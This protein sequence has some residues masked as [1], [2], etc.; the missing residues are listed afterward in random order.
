MKD[1]IEMKAAGAAGVRV[2]KISMSTGGAVVP[3][4]SIVEYWRHMYS[5]VHGRRG[6]DRVE[7]PVYL[8]DLEAKIKSLKAEIDAKT[9]LIINLVAVAS[10]VKEL[11]PPVLINVDAVAHHPV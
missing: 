4:R 11:L 9:A 7:G 3:S 2:K 8:Q 10:D 1:Y 6:D 5:D